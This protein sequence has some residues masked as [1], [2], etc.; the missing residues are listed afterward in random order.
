VLVENFRS[1]FMEEL[2][3]GYGD[4]AES[5]P[6]LIYLSIRGM[7]E[8][9]SSK[10]GHDLNFIATSG[11]GDWFLENGANYSSTFADVLGGVFFPLTKLLLHLANPNRRGM[12]L[13][14][15]A[16]EGFRNFYLPKAFESVK[17]ETTEFSQTNKADSFEKL[18]GSYPNSRFYRCSDDQWISLQ[19]IQMKHW[20][21]FCKVVNRPEWRD[22]AEDK[23]LVRE[24]E[25]LFLESPAHSWEAL[26][27]E[28][29]S[30]LFRVVPW[31]EH[32]QESSARTHLSLDPLTWVG[33]APNRNLTPSPSLGQDSFGIAHELGLTNE[34]ISQ[35]LGA[36]I[37]A[38]TQ[39][40]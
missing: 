1:G 15:H 9:L 36:G 23:S 19:A 26:D 35:L 40:T 39:S 11:C 21:Q 37:L 34:K 31:K 24:M 6:D 18:N 3:L 22:R 4:L 16:D 8:K 27:P 17:R 32:L 12:H 2:G 5:N 38:Q 28:R 10:P 7:S 14:A 30:C 13:I 20:E 33:F 29:K 25:K